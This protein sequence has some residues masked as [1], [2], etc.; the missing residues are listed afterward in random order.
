VNAPLH[1]EPA[2]RYANTGIRHPLAS[3]YPNDPTLRLG[4]GWDFFFPGLAPRAS[5]GS[6]NELDYELPLY[7]AM[8]RRLHCFVMQHAAPADVYAPSSNN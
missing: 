4:S 2:H 3:H 8:G 5:G 6:P 1:A 7:G